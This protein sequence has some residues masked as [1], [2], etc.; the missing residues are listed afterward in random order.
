MNPDSQAARLLRL[1][2]DEPGIS[3]MQIQQT[4]RPFVS[5]PRARISDLRKLGYDIVCERRPDGYEGFRVREAPVQLGL[6]VA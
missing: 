3:T 6:G 5:N 1:I 4:M 2:R